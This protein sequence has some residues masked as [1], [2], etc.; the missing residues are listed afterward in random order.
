MRRSPSLSAFRAFA[1]GATGLL[2]VGCL[3]LE[4]TIALHD[5]GPGA[6]VTERLC[7]TRELLELDRAAP[8]AGKVARWL[9]R[10]SALE[11]MQGMGK[12]VSLVEHRQTKKPDGSLESVSV[13]RIP[14][15]EDLRITNPLL[16]ESPPSRSVRFI[17]SPVKNP[18]DWRHGTVGVNVAEADGKRGQETG[19]HGDAPLDLQAYRDLEPVFAHL[20]K[21]LR[22][23]VR[24]VTPRPVASGPVRGAG[25]GAK[26]VTLFSISDDDLDAA[27]NAFIRNEEAMLSI[28]QLDLFADSILAHTRGF[29]VNP[30]LPVL[31]HHSHG[32]YHPHH[33]WIEPTRYMEKEYFGK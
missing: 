16:H 33:F 3:Q 21:G 18:K 11:R 23:T 15:L 17:L 29:P 28:L 1:L 19:K 7:V 31:R 14:N 27:G 6:T 12:G 20:M 25:K 30:R 2:C 22:V 4:L 26:T 9:T 13:F 32:L 10:E 24:L 5:D 8:A